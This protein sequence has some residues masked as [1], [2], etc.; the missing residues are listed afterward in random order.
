LALEHLWERL[1]ASVDNSEFRI[2]AASSPAPSLVVDNALI[3]LPVTLGGLGILSFK[4][5]APLAY[6][7]AFEA[8]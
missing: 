1:H 2:R 7:A 8:L 6:A 5:C 3:V 4:T